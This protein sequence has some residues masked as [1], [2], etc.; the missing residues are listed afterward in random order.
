VPILL[1]SIR[2]DRDRMMAR[3]G[4][5]PLYGLDDDN[6]DDCVHQVG[7]GDGPLEGLKAA[8]GRAGDGDQM[9]DPEQS[10]SAFSAATMSRTVIAGKSGP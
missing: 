6:W 10:S 5:H 2:F 3:F 8:V 4:S 7:V 9:L 1:H